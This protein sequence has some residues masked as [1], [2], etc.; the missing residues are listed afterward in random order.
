[1]LPSDAS[2]ASGSLSPA[3]PWHRRAP[4]RRA[5]RT[6]CRCGLDRHPARLRHCLRRQ[7]RAGRDRLVRRGRR[8]RRLVNNAALL[9]GRRPFQEIP[10]DEWDRMMAVNVRG[11]FLCCPRGVQ[12]HAQRWLDRQ[13]LVDH[14]AQRL[15]GLPALRRL[16]GRRDLDDQDT[17]LRARPA[18]RSG[19]TAS[20]PGS[21]RPRALPCSAP[22]TRPRPRS[23]G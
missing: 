11:T 18:S 5:A 3:A 16:E 15:A 1:M 2:R 23:D 22:T 6:W 19:S 10:I 21:R 14:R 20:V 4:C 8:H 9:V 7:R 13:R 17:G 12:A